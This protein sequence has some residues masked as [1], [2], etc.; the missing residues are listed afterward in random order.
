MEDSTALTS[1]VIQNFKSSYGACP[2]LCYLLWLD[3][4]STLEVLRCAFIAESLVKS[5]NS[6]KKCAEFNVEDNADAPKNEDDK[7]ILLQRIVNL[8][9]IILNVESNEIRSFQVD[10]NGIIESWPLKKDV[11]HIIEFIASFIASKRV[12]VS[13]NVLKYILEYLTSDLP[14]SVDPSPRNEASQREKQVLSLLKVVPQMDWD[15]SSVLDQCLKAQ[16]FQVL[17]LLGI[18]FDF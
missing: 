9:I 3:A 8:L 11:D 13:G 14:L 4:E 16:F 17:T 6:M 15:S 18:S 1:K 10:E 12:T 2:N 7:N 5:N